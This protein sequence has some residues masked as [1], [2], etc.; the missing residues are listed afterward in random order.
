LKS[1]ILLSCLIRL[2]AGLKQRATLW[3]RTLRRIKIGSAIGKGPS[4]LPRLVLLLALSLGAGCKYSASPYYGQ[5]VVADEQ[6]ISLVNLPSTEKTPLLLEP[7][8]QVIYGHPTLLAPGVLI[9]SSAQR[10]A[11]FNLHTRNLVDLGEGVWPTYVPEHQLLFFWQNSEGSTQPRKRAVLVRSL[12][13]PANEKVVSTFSGVWISRIVQISS[14]EVVFYG[15]GSRVWKYS[16]GSSS[17]SP[18]GVEKCLPMAW[19]RKTR[20]L[21]CQDVYSHKIYLSYLD[22]QAAAVPVKSYEV[23]GYSPTYDAIICSGAYGSSWEL[24][25]GWAIVAYNFRDRRTVRLTWVG[26]GATGIL[27]D[28]EGKQL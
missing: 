5:L 10:L 17:L 26:P 3:A 19:R 15:A 23:L 24:Q 25:V 8:S 14:D 13:G 2:S 21:I 28:G 4:K 1:W 7:K 11:R 12:N 16:I 6:G 27:L 18:T 9:F 22:G 20:Q